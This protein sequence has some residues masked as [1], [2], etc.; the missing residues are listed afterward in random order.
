MTEKKQS[1]NDLLRGH[2]R[3]KLEQ[4]FDYTLSQN[5]KQDL[6]EFCLK[7]KLNQSKVRYAYRLML[8]QVLEEYGLNPITV[9]YGTRIRHN[10]WKKFNEKLNPPEIKKPTIQTE[11]SGQQLV[12]E[13]PPITKEQKQEYEEIK[14]K[15]EE[16]KKVYAFT[17]ESLKQFWVGIWIIL[18]L[19]WKLMEDLSEEEKEILARLWSPFFQKY[20]PEWVPLLLV[21]AIITI[22]IFAKY[23]REAKEIRKQKQLEEK[24]NENPI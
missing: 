16:I 2:I 3:I 21:P 20:V 13:N 23:I 17:S 8:K 14:T 7:Y 1:Q 10:H 24:E 19:K 4:K 18:K 5:R 22:G 11:A 15:V 9:G 12:L 6:D